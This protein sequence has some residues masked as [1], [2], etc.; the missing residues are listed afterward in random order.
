MQ[1]VTK[2]DY[3]ANTTLLFWHCRLLD[4]FSIDSFSITICM[5]SYHH[6]LL[7]V[8]FQCFFMTGE[9]Y[10]ELPFNT[11]HLFVKLILKNSVYPL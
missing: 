5:Y 2:A 8:T 4:I 6:N 11:G 10:I 1:L 9:Y 7:P 3:P